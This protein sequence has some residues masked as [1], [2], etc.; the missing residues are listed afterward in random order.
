MDPINAA[1]SPTLPVLVLVE[2]FCKVGRLR[3][4]GHTCHQDAEN[5]CYS[6]SHCTTSATPARS[7]RKP[8]AGCVWSA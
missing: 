2:R 7:V 1:R 8:L 4:P 5:H 3:G 6:S